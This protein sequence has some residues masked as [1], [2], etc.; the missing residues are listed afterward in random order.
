MLI[1]E[2]IPKKGIIAAIT[3]GPVNWPT[4][5]QKRN[6]ELPNALSSKEVESAT[7]IVAVGNI[8]P[9]AIPN[10]TKAATKRGNIVMDPENASESPATESP[11]AR[12]M[13]LPQIRRS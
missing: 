6:I 12:A 5:K 3:R 7:K 9:W 1:E 10:A 8:K 13:V 11:T 4:S 2:P